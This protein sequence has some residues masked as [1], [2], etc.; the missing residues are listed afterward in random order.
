VGGEV[1]EQVR[2]AELAPFGVEV[3]VAA[4]AVG[5]DD[6]AVPL[7]EQRPG[8]EAVAAGR[9]PEDRGA[10]V[11]AA[12]SVRL[13]PAVFQPVSSMLTT[14][15]D[16]ISCSSLVWGAASASPVRC[17]IASTEPVESSTPNSSRASS[18]APRRETRF[19]GR[20]RHDRSLQP[21][22]ER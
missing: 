16:L 2:P 21:R 7:A 18:V 10:A 22:H 5:A 14:G 15:A 19:S 3:V 6:P 4:P 11:R 20:E 17:T 1:A 13:P 9:D 8:L 12:Q